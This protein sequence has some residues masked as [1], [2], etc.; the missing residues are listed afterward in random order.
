MA[1]AV[2]GGSVSARPV[3]TAFVL[4]LL[5]GI[6]NANDCSFL[7]FGQLPRTLAGECLSA[8]SF[9]ID[10]DCGP[11]HDLLPAAGLSAGLLPLVLCGGEERSLLSAC[12]YSAVG[13]LSG[14]CLC[15]EN[16]SGQRRC[17]QH[18]IAVHTRYETSFG[19]STLQP[20]RS[21]AYA[22]PYL[23]PVCGFADLRCA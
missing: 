19:V 14:S 13:Q 8:N 11:C 21:G 10:V 22:Y 3:C 20:V 6:A 15:L 18:L 5:V 1:S 9:S 7:D 16:N 12:D 2:V 23:Y 4:Q 17:A